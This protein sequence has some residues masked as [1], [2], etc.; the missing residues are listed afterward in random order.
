L[1]LGVEQS[2]EIVGAASKRANRIYQRSA[3]ELGF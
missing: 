2:I 1:Q 3:M